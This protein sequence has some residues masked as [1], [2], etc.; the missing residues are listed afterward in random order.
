[1][2]STGTGD[3]CTTTTRL[4]RIYGA[5]PNPGLTSATRSQV[6]GAPTDVKRRRVA[7]YA[8]KCP[9]QFLA[10]TAASRPSPPRR[11]VSDLGN[12]YRFARSNRG[13]QIFPSVNG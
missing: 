6:D 13:Q 11:L 5:H 12:A 8:R 2:I 4:P 1:M 10:A 7:L 9:R 3:P